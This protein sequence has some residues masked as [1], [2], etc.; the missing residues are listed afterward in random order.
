MWKDDS[1]IEDMI[2][3]ESR[4][5]DRVTDYLYHVLYYDNHG[6]N[7]RHEALRIRV[8][9]KG[10]VGEHSV[11]N[12][13]G[14]DWGRKNAQLDSDN[15]YMQQIDTWFSTWSNSATTGMTF[16]QGTISSTGGSS[17]TGGQYIYRGG[18]IAI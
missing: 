3:V 17:G 8:N 13:H 7:G 14:N 4:R 15:N 18:Y 5:H 10:Q 16:S 9:K 2:L 11:F 1:A 12:L 6:E